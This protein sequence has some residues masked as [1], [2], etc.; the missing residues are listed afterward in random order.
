MIKD[1]VVTTILSDFNIGPKLYGIFASGRLEELLEVN[2]TNFE[3]KNIL[4]EIVS[5]GKSYDSS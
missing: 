4:L 3:I 1:I 5:I 2:L